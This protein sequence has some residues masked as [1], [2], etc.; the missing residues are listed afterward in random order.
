MGKGVK[1]QMS[2]VWSA[3][4]Y[5]GSGGGETTCR[6]AA[7]QFLLWT[8]IGKRRKGNENP[9]CLYSANYYRFSPV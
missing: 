4:P 9:I 3:I 8:G 5:F 2:S 1:P 7:W 6:R